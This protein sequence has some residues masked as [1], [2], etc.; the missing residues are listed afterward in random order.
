MDQKHFQELNAASVIYPEQFGF[1]WRIDVSEFSSLTLVGNDASQIND[2]DGA[3]N[4]FVAGVG[5]RPEYVI[6]EQNGLPALR[7][8]GIT[9]FMTCVQNFPAT[10]QDTWFFVFQSDGDGDIE[11]T[12]FSDYGSTSR[13]ML[14]RGDNRSTQKMFFV[15]DGL[16]DSLMVDYTLT[17][18][19]GLLIV[20][21]DFGKITADYNG[22]FQQT[23]GTYLLTNYDAANYPSL[24]TQ[25]GQL[26]G[27]PPIAAHMFKGGLCA[28][29][30][31]PRVMGLEEIAML[32]TYAL[33]KWQ[34]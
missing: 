25:T 31:A 1:D 2:L 6:N 7:F 16:N 9:E 13:L 17:T 30:R 3:G 8:D 14:M 18:S 28:A 23:T 21:R 29:A 15:R 11:S 20:T 27:D 26:V 22:A 12:L 4:N 19:Y 34:T 10:S 33:Q 32:K 24:G 5:E